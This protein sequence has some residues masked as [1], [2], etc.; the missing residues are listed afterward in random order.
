M[1]LAAAQT[2]LG[3]RNLP[4]TCVFILTSLSPGVALTTATQW[5]QGALQVLK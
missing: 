3:E 2:R 4:I 1:G 5:I